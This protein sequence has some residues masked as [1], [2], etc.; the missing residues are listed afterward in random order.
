[1]KITN[2]MIAAAE[3]KLAEVLS[4]WH[5]EMPRDGM[6]QVLSAALQSVVTEEMVENACRAAYPGWD[7]IIKEAERVWKR[8]QM[9]SAIS[10]ALQSAA[11]TPPSPYAQT[12]G[13]ADQIISQIEELFPNWRAYR[14]LCRLH[15]LRASRATPA[16]GGQA[17]RL[18]SEPATEYR[19]KRQEH[20]T[21]EEWEALFAPFPAN[22]R[23]QMANLAAHNW[24][25]IHDGERVGAL[26]PSEYH[27]H[28]LYLDG[29]RVKMTDEEQNAFFP[30]APDEKR[31][32]NGYSTVWRTRDGASL[33]PIVRQR[34]IVMP[35]TPAPETTE[36]P[37]PPSKVREE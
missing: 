20:V 8:K 13:P 21:R 36:A 14:D 2:E 23:H 16:G 3:L 18:L 9:H 30:V 17:M 37:L 35:T 25:I 29:S 24:H 7:E 19:G 10:A 27:G 34:Q 1:M 26:A 32:R 22:V 33:P 11:D 31:G 4:M 12:V 28:W 5:Y 15:H 6:E